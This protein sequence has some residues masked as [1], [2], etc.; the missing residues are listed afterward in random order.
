[1][2]RRPDR[3]FTATA[4]RPADVTWDRAGNIY[5][6]DGFGP[7]NRVA[8]FTKD[9]NFVKSGTDRMARGSSTASAH[10]SDAAAT[11]T[12]RMPATIGSDL[13]R[14]G[15][16]QVAD[17]EYRH[18]AGICVSGGSLQ[19]LYSSNSNDSR[20]WITENLQDPVEWAGRRAGSARRARWRRSSAWSTPSTAA[21]KTI[22]GWANL[23]LARQKVTLRR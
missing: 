1:M 21:R 9:G 17:H 18:A 5:V 4:S 2:P 23:E 11:S 3:A 20:A 19:Y 14:R 12:W 13:R 15:D 8:K 6:A 10:C 16:V 7:N 22:C